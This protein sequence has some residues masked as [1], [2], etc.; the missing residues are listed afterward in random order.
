MKK[1][2]TNKLKIKLL[3]NN[4]QLDVASEDNQHNNRQIDYQKSN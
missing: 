4:Q 2:L 1:R 3:N